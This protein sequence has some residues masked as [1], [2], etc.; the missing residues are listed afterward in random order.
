MTPIR[1]RLFWLV[2]CILACYLLIGFY[3]QHDMGLGDQ[4]DFARASS[5]VTTQ[6]FQTPPARVD[7]VVESWSSFYHYY[8]LPFWKI[9]WQ[10]VWPITP[11][12]TALLWL[13]GI[14]LNVLTISN[15]V[16][17]L[18]SLSFVAKVLAFLLLFVFVRWVYHSI[19]SISFLGLVGGLLVILLTTTAYLSYWNSFFLEM[20]GI[21]Y[22]LGFVFSLVFFALQP[23]WKRFL[24]AVILLLLFCT[25]RPS[26]LYFLFFGIPLLLFLW[27]QKVRK[28]PYLFGMAGILSPL[29]LFAFFASILVTPAYSRINIYD[30]LFLGVLKFSRNPEKH[31]ERWGIPEAIVCVN[32]SP[33][34]PLGSEC[35]DKLIPPLSFRTT[36]DI[37]LH[38]PRLI[39]DQAIFAAENMQDITI[40]YLAR[41]DINDPRFPNH[42]RLRVANERAFAPYEKQFF[43]FWAYLKYHYFPRG[44]WLFIVLAVFSL[45]SL[46][47]YFKIGDPTIQALSVPGFLLSF[48]CGLEIYVTM[49]AGGVIELIR[50]LFLANLMF[51]IALGIMVGL[52]LLLFSR[53][54]RI[55]FGAL[56][57]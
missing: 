47:V 22:L 10:A 55:P 25:S 17:A 37:V 33:H 43:N 15:Q 23:N 35:M 21:I 41:Y 56:K 28:R 34:F 29:V 32:I 36:I 31:L 42:L 52:V 51:D 46:W 44:I 6:P 4:G 3:Y 20:G 19:Q 24:L 16:L 11:S 40:D 12:S 39:W 14:L 18:S 45:F 7:E 30:S 49:L 1:Q 50:H 9:N 38:E 27:Y 5:F 2:S 53:I 8:Y 26:Y 57:K 48:L 54:W 13:P